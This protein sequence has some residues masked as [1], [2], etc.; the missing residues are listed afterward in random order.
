MESIKKPG[1]TGASCYAIDVTQPTLFSSLSIIYAVFTVSSFIT[2]PIVGAVGAKWS[3]VA[4]AFSYAI[5]LASFLHLREWLLYVTSG[6]V[7][8]G[9]AR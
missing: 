5:M 6:V 1:F 4:G 7:G 9:A 2:P 3:M 8:F